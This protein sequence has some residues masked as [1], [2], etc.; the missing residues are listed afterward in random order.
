MVPFAALFCGA[1][2]SA[3]R[4]NFSLFTDKKVDDKS[5]KGLTFHLVRSATRQSP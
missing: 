2:Q 4:Q 1:L 3:K 5:A